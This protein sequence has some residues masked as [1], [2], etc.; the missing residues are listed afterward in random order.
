MTA[1]A[2]IVGVPFLPLHQH[3]GRMIRGGGLFVIGRRTGSTRLILHTEL[4]EPINQRAGPGHSRRDWAIAQ[5]LN[6]L[7]VSLASASVMV[8]DIDDDDAERHT[9]AEFWAPLE[10]TYS[11]E[12]AE[13]PVSTLLRRR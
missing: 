8:D 2:T 5:G 4:A 6:E 3:D 10:G 9:D 1:Y 7:L 11:R 13:I 12:P